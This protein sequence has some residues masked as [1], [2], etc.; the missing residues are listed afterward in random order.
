MT[1]TPRVT[2]LVLMF[3][4]AGMPVSAAAEDLGPTINYISADAVYINVG[5]GAG[6]S[7]G[8]RVEV[9]R[10]GLVIAELEIT[11]ISSQ[12]A[13]CRIVSQTDELALGD[14]VFFVRAREKEA[15]PEQPEPQA[16]DQTEPERESGPRRIRGHV[17][18]QNQWYRDLGES[19]LSSVQ[20][21]VNA[22]LSVGD[23]FGL[24]GT[25]R[26]RHHTRLY[27]RSQA[28]STEPE[29]DEWIHHL[30]EFG[31]YFPVFGDADAIA[32]GRIINPYMRG[33]GYI[34]GGYVALRV[35]SGFR[36]GVA[37]GTEPNLEDSSFQ[38][39]HRR[40]GAFVTYEAGSYETRRLMTTVALSGSYREGLIDREF[41]Y[42]QNVVSLWQRLSIYHSIEIDINRG[43]REEAEG[44]VV[45]FSNT[46]FTTN[47]SL[48]RWL[49][50]DASYDARRNFRDLRTYDSP[51]SLFDDSYTT[52]YSG[53]VSISMPAGIRLRGR[54]GERRRLDDE[55][56]NRFGSASFHIRSFPI[57]GHSMMA[58]LSVSETPYVTGYRTAFTY[59]FP[60]LRR[61]RI[62]LGGGEYRYEQEI[63]TTKTT[64]G[65]VGFHH[66]FGRRYYVSGNCRWLTGGG[67]NSTQLLT[68]AGL[69][70]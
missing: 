19:A 4:A 55:Y 69:S 53:G 66:T 17:A 3:A 54:G 61:T 50:L 20:P 10:T 7:I 12:S 57:R 14:T 64:F 30:S 29:T 48:F 26:I 24:G 44:N 49:K 65:E 25:L 42:V 23:I 70:F 15:E 46:Y 37:G 18:I 31:L 22:R 41:G 62:N 1:K 43:W 35:Y 33:L 56:V 58:R 8:T 28:L 21:G 11:H 32:F 34:D 63:V 52:G 67:L 13:A 39:D 38:P 68:E 45:S 27:H 47:A 9:I 16:T 60:L 36:L 5:S 51:D 2:L 6:L 59:R 40:Y